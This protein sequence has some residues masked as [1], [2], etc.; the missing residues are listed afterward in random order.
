MIEP[1]TLQELDVSGPWGSAIA[2]ATSLKAGF[3]PAYNG[4][5]LVLW[6]P[7][8]SPQKLENQAVTVTLTVNGIVSTLFLGYVRTAKWIEKP[9]ENA[10]YIEC[11][12]Q[13]SSADL[14]VCNSPRSA[15]S[16][17]WRAFFN[18]G[19]KPNCHPTNAEFHYGPDAIMW[20]ARKAVLKIRNKYMQRSTWTLTDAQLNAVL[21]LEADIRPYD[22]RGVRPLA[23]ICEIL[24][25][26]GCRLAF[27]YGSGACTPVVF[28]STGSG[29]FEV[30][31]RLGQVSSGSLGAGP[32]GP[33]STDQYDHEVY[34]ISC[35]YDARNVTP[36][37]Y[38]ICERYL[39][40]CTYSTQG[41]SPLLAAASSEDKDYFWEYRVQVANYAA[42]N[43]GAA[44]AAGSRPRPLMR[45]LATRRSAAGTYHTAAEVTATPEI[46]EA[47]DPRETLALLDTSDS[48]W[49]R[50]SGG[51]RMWYDP[52][53]KGVAIRLKRD[54]TL[55]TAVAGTTKKYNAA[56]SAPDIRFTAATEIELTRYWQASSLA[57]DVATDRDGVVNCP[58]LR[59]SRRYNTTLPGATIN[60][61]T[62][63]EAAAVAVYRNVD[64]E[65][66]DAATG[67]YSQ[68][69]TRASTV[70]LY[71]PFLHSEVPIGAKLKVTPA[72]TY[73]G[74]S[75]N[76]LVRSANWNLGEV[77][78]RV[79]AADNLD[80]VEEG[81]VS[82]AQKLRRMI[83]SLIKLRRNRPVAA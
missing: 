32:A 29:T 35:G 21:A 55:A 60:T 2:N 76:E 37:L 22:A 57:V 42:H 44:L 54:V 7:E 39:H 38:A 51:V 4:L 74:L 75:G 52:D 72:P 50:I 40:E 28:D 16:I 78:V 49:K 48:T 67:P 31:Y 24:K 8:V 10:V 43:C 73:A 34:E 82:Q 63:Q 61:W 71:L 19:G 20:T 11:D 69:A 59:P 1:W 6:D 17:G 36:V 53:E 64:N 41:A 15:D 33:Y 56:A 27:R 79:E 66:E 81:K 83:A 12:G 18:E 9:D 30:F 25:Q 46:G 58:S 13:E 62:V 14:D 3:A 5:S 65:L 80:L 70:E 45:E 23:A 26:A 68:R 77:E 47:V